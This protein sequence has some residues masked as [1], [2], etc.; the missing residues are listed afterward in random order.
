MSWLDSNADGIALAFWLAVAGLA[1]L[2]IARFI[3]RRRGTTATPEF[4]HAERMA[5]YRQSQPQ[6]TE[7]PR[8]SLP[9]VPPSGWVDQRHQD[10]DEYAPRRWL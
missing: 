1:V 6:S 3:E 4:D 8:S 9:W 2:A 7:T 5:S 10:H